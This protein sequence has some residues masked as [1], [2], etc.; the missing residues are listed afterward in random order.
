MQKIEIKNYGQMSTTGRLNLMCRANSK[1]RK[2]FAIARQ[3]SCMRRNQL[4]KSISMYVVINGF[5]SLK[6]LT[7]V[8][9]FLLYLSL[10]SLITYLS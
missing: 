2:F 1:K 4:L 7:I 10:Q 3:A 6:T 8:I 5:R 9:D